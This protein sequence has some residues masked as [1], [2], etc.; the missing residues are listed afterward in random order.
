M[1]GHECISMCLFCA[2]QMGGNL[3]ILLSDKLSYFGPNLTS[4][5]SFS[6]LFFGPPG[7]KFENKNRFPDMPN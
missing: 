2:R 3:Q 7:V 1:C 5:C 6:V 4:H